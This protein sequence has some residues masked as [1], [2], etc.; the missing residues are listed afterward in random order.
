MGKALTENGSTMFIVKTQTARKW[1]NRR[2]L[3]YS[4][5]RI[6]RRKTLPEIF[7]KARSSWL[8]KREWP[9][10]ERGHLDWGKEVTHNRIEIQTLNEK[11]NLWNSNHI[12]WNLTLILQD[13]VKWYFEISYLL[14]KTILSSGLVKTKIKQKKWIYRREVLL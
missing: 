3:I 6:V 10:V 7:P 13:D 4:W 14:R 1:K 11:I 5:N 9:Y 12:C 2:E 8:T